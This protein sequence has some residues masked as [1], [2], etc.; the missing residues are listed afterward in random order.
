ML[1]ISNGLGC[2]ALYPPPGQRWRTSGWRTIGSEIAA[3]A[4]TQ[5]QLHRLYSEDVRWRIRQANVCGRVDAPQSSR[6]RLWVLWSDETPLPAYQTYTVCRMGEQMPCS[7]I[8]GP[9]TTTRVL[10]AALLDLERL[11][12]TATSLGQLEYVATFRTALRCRS[13]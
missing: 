12:V 9:N 7:K 10:S 3:T 1:F 6:R 4:R 13:I 11:P 2:V 8:W 5:H